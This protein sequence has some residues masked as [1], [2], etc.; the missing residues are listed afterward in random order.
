MDKRSVT[1]FDGS[2]DRVIDIIG[3]DPAHLDLQETQIKLAY[4]AGRRAELIRAISPII[5]DVR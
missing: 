4:R 1:V 5:K 2:E 3:N